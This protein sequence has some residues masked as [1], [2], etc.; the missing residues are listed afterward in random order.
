MTRAGLFLAAAIAICSAAA[1]AADDP[2]CEGCPSAAP[3]IFER[4][5]RPLSIEIES[6]I[7]FGRMALRGQASG[8]AEIDPQ[9][10]ENRVDGG[11]IDLGGTSYQGRAR[12]TGE[13]LRP[14]RI[15]LPQTVLLRSSSGGEARLSEFVTDLPA[16]PM[17]DA[18]GVLEFA[19]GA[20]ISSEGAR[21]GDF[22]GRIHIRVD[23]F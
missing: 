17:L 6:G 18:N 4:A 10:G 11:M 7:Q 9:T 23:Y 3:S 14:V 2:A 20:R 1:E 19:F 16:V 13:P 21:G 5:D 8:G 12:V 22:R 15:E